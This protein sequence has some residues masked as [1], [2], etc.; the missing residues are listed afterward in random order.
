MRKETKTI[1]I[2]VSLLVVVIGGFVLWQED[3]IQ[4]FN[5][6]ASIPS[7]TPI[8]STPRAT[9]GPSPTIMHKPST[10]RVLSPT[11]TTYTMNTIEL[12]YTINSKVLW[13]YYSV[14]ESKYVDI[15][16]LMSPNA[17]IPFEG[18]ITLN[19]SEGPHRLRIAVQTEESR[20]SS[21]PIAYQTID[22]II[23]TTNAP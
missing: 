11:N 5:N 15:Q 22:F 2:T 3:K 23:S 9:A 18:N 20:F 19:L 1:A 13:S 14:D 17:L 21:V 7:P 12:V 4:L 6:P 8:E 10:L 16:H